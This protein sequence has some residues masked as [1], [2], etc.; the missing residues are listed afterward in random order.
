VLGC[1]LGARH[2]R[3]RPIG[4]AYIDAHADFA[5]PS[6]SQTGSVASMCLAMAVG[7]GETPLARLAGDV[8]LVRDHDVA[9]VGRRDEIDA[10]YG[11]EALQASAVL[12]LPGNAVRAAGYRETA[13]AVLERIGRPELDGF[14]IHVDAD[15]L[16]P[17]VV[18]AVDSPEP[19]GPVLDELAALL[20]PL[21]RH[22][23]AVGMELTIY[24]P[25]LDP[26]G[27]SATRLVELLERILGDRGA[28]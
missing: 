7:R 13:A 4:L 22:P 18:P 19:G 14:W 17:S 5:T 27:S 6:G 16:D 8:P 3:Q 24:D 21:V 11:H 15:V 26:D 10:W 9:L 12:D 25:K 2:D 20:V 28:V 1:L 23:G